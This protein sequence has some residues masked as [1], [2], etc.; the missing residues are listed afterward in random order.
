MLNDIKASWSKVASLE[1]KLVDSTTNQHWVQ[2]MV[3][4]ERMMM[5]T[6]EMSINSVT[7]TMSFY[8]PYSKLKPIINALNPH[9]II[10]DALT[11]G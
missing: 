1:P 3:G 9:I 7:G 11:N 4:N 10:F 6:F 8:L 2:M 5:I